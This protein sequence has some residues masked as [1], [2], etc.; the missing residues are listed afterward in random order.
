MRSI[1]SRRATM[2]SV[3]AAAS[4]AAFVAP[5]AASAATTIGAPVV[6]PEAGCP[7]GTFQAALVWK[8]KRVTLCIR[9]LRD[10]ARPL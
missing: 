4:G 9:P 7:D 8:G 3:L 6:E 10:P 1:T 2:L 5:A